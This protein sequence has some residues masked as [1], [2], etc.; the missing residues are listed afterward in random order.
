MSLIGSDSDIP[1]KDLGPS[2][3]TP[4]RPRRAPS[5]EERQVDAE[6]SKAALLDAALE[7]FAAK[8]FAGAR[9][10]DIADR[11][12]VSKDLIAYHFGSKRG[13]YRTVQE[14]WIDRRDSFVDFSRSLPEN[15]SRYLHE[16]LRDPRPIRMLVWL[17]LADEEEGEEDGIDVS[18]D[19]YPDFAVL[20][21]RQE[22]GEYGSE[23]DPAVLQLMMMG[24]V[25]APS[26]FPDSV[27]R[28]FGV[29]A[30]DPQFEARYLAG[31]LHVLRALGA[32]TQTT[33]RTGD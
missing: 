5:P 4:R 7:E 27:T 14:A 15:L 10:R 24:A 18:E 28:L 23:V 32:Q 33:D 3:P 21:R 16:V 9:V 29:D 2:V 19:V 30:S 22:N 11:A 13:L 1:S 12:G 6:R 20:V 8:G 31:L 17:G 26:V 25:T